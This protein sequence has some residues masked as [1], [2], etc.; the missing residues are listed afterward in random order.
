MGLF[1]GGE[2][3][4]ADSPGTTTTAASAPAT[5]TATGATSATATGS[6]RSAR[7][8]EPRATTGP[9]PHQPAAACAAACF[10]VSV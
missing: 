1:E 3:T 2:P 4:D 9:E 7:E 6:A 10:L 8:T 5:T